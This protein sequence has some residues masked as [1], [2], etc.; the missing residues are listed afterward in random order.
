MAQRKDV[1]T[2]NPEQVERREHVGVSVA[3]VKAIF[4][5]KA[6]LVSA[7]RDA[8]LAGDA[9]AIP[10][11]DRDWYVQIVDESDPVAKLSAY[12]QAI[13]TIQVRVA[14]VHLLVRDAG[15]SDKDMAKLWR[16]EH[17][18]R[19]EEMAGVVRSMRSQGTLR[20][21]LSVE[22]AIA[23]LWCYPIP[24][25]TGSSRMSVGGLSRGTQRGYARR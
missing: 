9:E 3:S 4:A 21:G 19:R 1:A 20:R 6:G 24:G 12:A 25:P 17:E 23:T 22:S 16:L 8:A 2:A 7:V 14:K 13:A 10:L 15:A 18:Q 5:N 11:A